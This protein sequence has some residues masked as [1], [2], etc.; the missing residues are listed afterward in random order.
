M[1]YAARQRIERIHASQPD[2]ENAEQEKPT[3]SRAHHHE[4]PSRH[5]ERHAIDCV[6]GLRRAAGIDFPYVFDGDGGHAMG[7]SRTFLF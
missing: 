6:Y 5:L 2:R 7:F 3:G 1:I 4:F